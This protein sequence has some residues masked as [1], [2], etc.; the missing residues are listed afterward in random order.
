[1]ILSL[2]EKAM[3]VK[4]VAVLAVLLF[5]ASLALGE[6]GDNGLSQAAPQGTPMMLLAAKKTVTADADVQKCITD[7]LA[8]SKLKDDS[9]TAKVNGGEAVLEGSVK[10]SA[11]KGN[12]SQIAKNCGA[13]KVTNNITVPSKP[14]PTPKPATS[15]KK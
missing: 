11:H 1:M 12:A 4:K 13:Q 15:P 10:V 6:C 14:A 8:S 5:C 2:E 9:I 3:Q 7:K